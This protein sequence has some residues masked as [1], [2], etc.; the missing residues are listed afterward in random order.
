MQP[1]SRQ[2]LIALTSCIE[3]VLMRHG[4]SDYNK[5]VARLGSQYDCTISDCVEKPE[6]LRDVLREVYGKKYDAMIEELKVELDE[7]ITVDKISWFVK[8]LSS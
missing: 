6:Y 3:V 1:F 4:G 2:H 8:S 5:V 7:L